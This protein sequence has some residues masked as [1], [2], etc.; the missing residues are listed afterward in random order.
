MNRF[1]IEK[2][3]PIPEPTKYP[4]AEMEV[5]DS[6]FDDQSSEGRIRGEAGRQSIGGKKFKVKKT[7]D[8]YRVW[9]TE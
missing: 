3:V 7:P 8:G 5:G 9:R 6:F 1:P 2:D 4:F